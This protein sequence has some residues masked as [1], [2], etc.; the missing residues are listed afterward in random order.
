MSLEFSESMYTQMESFVGKRQN[1]GRATGVVDSNKSHPPVAR[2]FGCSLVTPRTSSVGVQSPA[3]S[4]ATAPESPTE[5]TPKDN[6]PG[7]TGRKQ[8]VVGTDNL[9]DFVKDFNCEYLARAEAQEKDKRVWRS[10]ILALDIAREARI[11]QKEA[12]VVSMDQKLYELE[13]EKTKKLGNMTSALLLLASSMDALIRFRI[14]SLSFEL[15]FILEVL[16]FLGV[17][18]CSRHF[19]YVPSSLANPPLPSFLLTMLFLHSQG[20]SALGVEKPLR[21]FFKASRCRP[22]AVDDSLPR[23]DAMSCLC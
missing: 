18:P 15:G 22:L 3:T 19:G 4:A 16:V 11:A 13:V 6:T 20:L 2:H 12:Q 8:K 21:Q 17:F 9:V 23:F 5:I 1:F 7:S 10:E 14:L